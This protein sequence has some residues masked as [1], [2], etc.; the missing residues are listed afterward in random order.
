M[1]VDKVVLVV[2]VEEAHGVTLAERWVPRLTQRRE[3][4]TLEVVAV[5]L[6]QKTSTQ[7]LVVLVL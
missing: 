2:A 1:A 5:E 4:P 3:H 7:V 6:T